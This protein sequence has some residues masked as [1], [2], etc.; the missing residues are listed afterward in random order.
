M[1]PDRMT[2]V[3]LHLI[4][5]MHM[6]VQLE[7]SRTLEGSESNDVVP[8]MKYQLVLMMPQTLAPYKSLDNTCSLVKGTLPILHVQTSP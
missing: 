6:K 7:S 8:K 1:I 4:W 5:N 2:L 3:T